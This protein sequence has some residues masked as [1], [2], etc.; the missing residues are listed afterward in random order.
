MP[1]LFIVLGIGFVVIAVRGTQAT[2]FSLLEKEF[3]G[4][5]NFVKWA[6]A[7]FILGAVGYIPVVR[8]VTRALLLLVLLV[9][10][11]KNGT[12]LFAKFNEAVA[13]PTAQQPPG[14]NPGV[15]NGLGTVGNIDTSS[16][17][18]GNPSYLQNNNPFGGAASDASNPLT[19]GDT[20]GTY[21]TP[22]NANVGISTDFGNGLI[23][24]TK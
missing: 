15:G 21:G 8:P 23:I 9:I 20:S 11:L 3:S 13:N 14:T 4:P 7:L 6:L 1:F 22:S 17:T 19:Y 16:L 5:N 10:F 18:G 24:N 12:G 2:A